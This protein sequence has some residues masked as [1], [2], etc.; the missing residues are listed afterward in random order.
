MRMPYAPLLSVVALLAGGVLAAGCGGSDVA[1]GTVQGPITVAD[2]PVAVGTVGAT[3]GADTTGGGATTGGAT[4]GGA[5]TG[6]A[7]GDPVAGK[8]VF[9]ANCASCH[10]LADAGATGTVGPNLDQLKPNFARVQAKVTN[11]GVVMP[12]LPLSDTDIANVAAYVS[13]VAG[14]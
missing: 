6:A 1:A 9:T 10:T 5:T 13:S 7:Q 14:K 2:K 4:T 8:A 12:K 11:G 3:A